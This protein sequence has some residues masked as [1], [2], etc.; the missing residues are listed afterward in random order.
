MALCKCEDNVLRCVIYDKAAKKP[1]NNDFDER[2]E[3][4]C[5][6]CKN[7]YV[8]NDLLLVRKKKQ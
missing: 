3:I 4:E 1:A 7:P 5:I 8:A 6:G 2:T